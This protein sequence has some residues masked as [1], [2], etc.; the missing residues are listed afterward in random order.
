MKAF[1][2]LKVNLKLHRTDPPELIDARVLTVDTLSE[3]EAGVREATSGVLSALTGSSAV[4]PESAGPNTEESG[5]LRK[6]F[7]RAAKDVAKKALKKV[8]ERSKD[9]RADEQGESQEAE[10]P[11]GQD[12]DWRG[13]TEWVGLYGAMG[14]ITE[15]SGSSTTGAGLVVE[16]LKFRFPI[17]DRA[18]GF[19]GLGGAR[20]QAA[21]ANAFAPQVTLSGAL[22]FGYGYSL[23]GPHGL[24]ISLGY[25]SGTKEGTTPTDVSAND[26]E[27]RSDVQGVQTALS[28]HYRLESVALRTG[29]LNQALNLEGDETGT[30]QQTVFFLGAAY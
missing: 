30:L 3:L 10:G 14:S 17:M 15:G 12:R 20:L 25:A 23:G 8:V 2:K 5:S 26:D 18:Y 21:D 7:K 4:S 9:K 6:S 13:D 29:V 19:L 24:E 27:V 1:G 16:F 28:Y 11:D 22:M